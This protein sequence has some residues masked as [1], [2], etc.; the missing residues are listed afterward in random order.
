MSPLVSMTIKLMVCVF[1]S[2]CVDVSILLCAFFSFFLGCLIHCHVQ[3]V[4]CRLRALIKINQSIMSCP[5]L[6]CVHALHLVTFA[7]ST[8]CNG[9]VLY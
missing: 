2:M 3:F 1:I 6:I 5:R 4:A 9:T 7:C 8:N